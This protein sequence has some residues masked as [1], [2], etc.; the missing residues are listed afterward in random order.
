MTEFFGGIQTNN[1]GSMKTNLEFLR[2]D[3]IDS[4]TFAGNIHTEHRKTYNEI[5]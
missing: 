5:K 2:S 3:K 1:F 4:V